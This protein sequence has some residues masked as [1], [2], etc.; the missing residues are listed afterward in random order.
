MAITSKFFGRTRKG[1]KVYAFELKNQSGSFVRIL[2]RG[3][4]IQALCVPDKNGVLTDVVLGFDNVAAY[5]DDPEYLGTLVGRVA[6][7]IADST[8]TLGGK[9][10]QL[11]PM[12]LGNTLHGGKVGF[13]HRIWA[14]HIQGDSLVLTL[15]S[16]D[17][18]EGYP[19]TLAVK[20]VYTFTEDNTLRIDYEAM[21]NAETVVNLT[22]HAYFNLS[23]TGTVD[24]QYMMIAADQFT[25][26]NERFL[27]T[28]KIL[29]VTDTPFDFRE[30]KK[31]GRDIDAPDQ[32]LEFGLGYD[33]N[34]VLNREADCVKAWSEETGITLTL[35]TDLPGL[36]FY[37]GNSL[38]ERKGKGGVEMP[39]RAGYCL[40]TQFFPDAP[41]HD[42][43]PSIVVQ[44]YERW[45]H[46]A[47]FS[48]GVL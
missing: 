21:S 38:P 39:K 10:Y 40:E 1:E 26:V 19:G 6:N 13:S 35:S 4:I 36:Q 45:K 11:Y 15:E 37:T 42:N 23:G 24:A 7:R 48:F 43:F 18:E 33:H 44:P 41:H 30:P 31:I 3:G 17:R 5:E 27:P 9:T 46:Y 25:E 12:E 22:N 32:Q 20:V 2:N 14:H 8:F 16:P 34:F 47:E 29:D 28:G